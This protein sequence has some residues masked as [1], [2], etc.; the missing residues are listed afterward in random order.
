[1]IF[2]NQIT[3][4]RRK[5]DIPFFGLSPR[6]RIGGKRVGVAQEASRVE[7]VAAL[8]RH[9]IPVVLVGENHLTTAHISKACSGPPRVDSQRSVGDTTEERGRSQIGSV[10]S[11]S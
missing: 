4:S 7:Y 11:L 3:G 6:W 2:S 9:L 5:T 1:M 8:V 10:E